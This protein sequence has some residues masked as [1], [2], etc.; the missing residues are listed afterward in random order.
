M[1]VFVCV[2]VAGER[3]GWNFELDEIAVQGGEVER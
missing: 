3:E 2:R 1:L